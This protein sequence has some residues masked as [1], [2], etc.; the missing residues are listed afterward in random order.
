MS[1]C[2]CIVLLFFGCALANPHK[3]VFFVVIHKCI[4]ANQKTNI[5]MLICYIEP[6]LRYSTGSWVGH[7]HINQSLEAAEM[8]F[9]KLKM[10]L[11]YL[12]HIYIICI[13]FKLCISYLHQVCHIYIKKHR[14]FSLVVEKWFIADIQ[15]LLQEILMF[16]R[17]VCD[18][19]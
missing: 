5:Q 11:H 14:F 4:L 6:N 2:Q 12:H 16:S 9:L 17:S 10:Y 13:I 8:C 1:I 15:V 18:C 19:D 3:Q 7:E